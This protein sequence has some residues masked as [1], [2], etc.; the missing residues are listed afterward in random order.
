MCKL[1]LSLKIPEPEF[2]LND[3]IIIITYNNKMIL[4]FDNVILDQNPVRLFGNIADGIF[5]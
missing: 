3:V 2:D 5:N 4:S 1:K